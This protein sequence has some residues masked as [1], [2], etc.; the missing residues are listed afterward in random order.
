MEFKPGLKRIWHAH[1]YYKHLSLHMQKRGARPL[2]L[3]AK[4][5]AAH[6]CVCQKYVDLEAPRSSEILCSCVFEHFEILTKIVKKLVQV[7]T[8]LGHL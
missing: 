3:Y 6:F 7:S 5:R 8:L 2:A 4:P 1:A